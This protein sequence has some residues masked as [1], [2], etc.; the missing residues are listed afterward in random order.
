MRDVV[1]ELTELAP[2]HVAVLLDPDANP[3]VVCNGSHLCVRERVHI[4]PAYMLGLYWVAL[5][6]PDHLQDD[7]LPVPMVLDDFGSLVERV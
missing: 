4:F 2:G 7:Y 3:A 6:L 1:T 5:A